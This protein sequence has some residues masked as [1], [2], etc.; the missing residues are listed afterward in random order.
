M[1]SRRLSMSPF[2]TGVDGFA[3]GK[4]GL[5]AVGFA[6]GGALCFSCAQIGTI[7]S[8]ANH[9][10]RFMMSPLGVNLYAI[11]THL[12]DET[13]FFIVSGFTGFSS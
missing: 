12:S 1:R 3:G 6:G 2:S 13:C 9:A 5:T 7:K 8:I 10:R 4:R 11:C